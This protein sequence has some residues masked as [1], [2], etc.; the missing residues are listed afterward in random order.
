MLYSKVR[1]DKNASEIYLSDFYN[2]V[3]PYNYDY[4]LLLDES[5]QRSD[6]MST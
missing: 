5:K 4:K 1:E 3:T 2:L 6:M